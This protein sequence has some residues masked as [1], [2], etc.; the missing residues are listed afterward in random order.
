MD[1]IKIVKKGRLQTVL[2][3]LAA[4]FLQ[5]ESSGSSLITVTNCEISENLRTATIFISVL[6]E[7]AEESALNFTKRKRRDFKTYVK[8]HSK[9]RHIPFF[10]FE[11]DKGEKN[12]QKI[13][14]LLK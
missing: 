1:D 5:T 2:K 12:R 11:I 3:E 10:D 9:L 13:E 4:N 6:P 14:S 7:T 8:S